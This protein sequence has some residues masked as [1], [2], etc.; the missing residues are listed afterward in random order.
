MITVLAGVVVLGAT[1]AGAGAQ[2]GEH[3][4][5][6]HMKMTSLRPMKPGDQ[7]RADAI[8]AASRVVADHYTDYHTALADGYQIFMP[9][10]AQDV[11]HFVLETVEGRGRFDKDKPPALLY[12][13]TKDGYKLVGVM[14]TARF[15]AG[16]AEL[17]ARIPLS[18]AQWHEHVNLCT[19]SSGHQGNWLMGDPKFGLDGSIATREACTAAGGMFLPHLAGW[20]THVYPYETDKAKVWGAG[21]D[22]DHGG[23]G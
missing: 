3:A 6:A 7:E 10:Q 2:E 22:D 16:E 4:M 18:I 23:R 11:Y 9:D 8:A 17:D 15:G 21:M 19:P 13:K 5:G 20:M 12:R 14:Y 1:R